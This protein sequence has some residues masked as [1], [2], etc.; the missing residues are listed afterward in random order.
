MKFFSGKMCLL[1]PHL[2]FLWIWDH[3]TYYFSLKWQKPDFT[4]FWNVSI[5]Y[6]IFV[7]VLIFNFV[8]V[9][10]RQLVTHE[11]RIY[12]RSCNS[13]WKSTIIVNRNLKKDNAVTLNTKRSVIIDKKNTVLKITVLTYAPCDLTEISKSPHEKQYVLPIYLFY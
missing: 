3:K 1:P 8:S 4:I 11:K 6:N 13:R 12:I 7:H 10:D 5:L 2:L 9:E